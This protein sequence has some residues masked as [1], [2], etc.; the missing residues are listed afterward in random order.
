MNA[1]LAFAAPSR[2]EFMQSDF[3]WLDDDLAKVYNGICLR[4]RMLTLLFLLIVHVRQAIK[5]L[6]RLRIITTRN[7]DF[8]TTFTCSQCVPKVHEYCVESEP[9]LLVDRNRLHQR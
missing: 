5:N 4:Y 6:S 8:H 3:H 9:R 2:K 1:L 7:Q